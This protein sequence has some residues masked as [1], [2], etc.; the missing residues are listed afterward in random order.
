MLML[1]A[2]LACKGPCAE[3]VEPIAC[4]ASA[5]QPDRTLVADPT[6]P[7]RG[8][9]GI[10]GGVHVDIDF[11]VEG[12]SREFEISAQ[13]VETDGTVVASVPRAVFFYTPSEP[14]TCGGEVLGVQIPFEDPLDACNREGETLRVELVAT[15][16]DGE[17]AL[18]DT[19][20]ALTVD[21]VAVSVLCTP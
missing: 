16:S 10:Q 7:M 6:D 21:E 19:T 12:M 13:I 17:Q 11:E 14:D 2:L 15:R 8:V 4:T 1:T 3:P 9:F 18:C 20:G 5:L